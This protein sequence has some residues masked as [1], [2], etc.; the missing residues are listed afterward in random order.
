LH[1]KT[2]SFAGRK[3]FLA[4]GGRH[5]NPA[6]SCL[7]SRSG[8]AAAGSKESRLPVVGKSAI[9]ADADAAA[10]YRAEPIE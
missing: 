4:R 6:P 7:G 5:L 1:W 2:L 9:V 10:R 3:V 8:A